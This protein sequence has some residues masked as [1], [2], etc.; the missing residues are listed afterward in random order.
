MDNPTKTI[1]Q[2]DASIVTRLIAGEMIL[3]P[4]RKHVG[5]MDHIYT[6]NETASRIW[7]L[8]DGQRSLA[9]ICQQMESEFEIDSSQAESDLNELVQSLLEIGAITEE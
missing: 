6:L 8:I 9:E 4:I 5:D 2:R 3:V 7:E 1:Y